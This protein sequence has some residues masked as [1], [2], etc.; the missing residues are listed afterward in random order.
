MFMQRRGWLLA[1]TFLACPPAWAGAPEGWVI[2][3]LWSPEYCKIHL[4]SKE[5]QCQE[6]RYFEIGGLQPQFRSGEEPEC[7]SGSLPAD[8]VD[9]A[10]TTLSNKELLRRI[11]RTQGACSGLGRDEYLIALD[12][13]R[14]RLVV[15]DEYSQV[16]KTP[17]ARSR[18]ALMESFRKS[19]PGLEPGQALPDCKGKWLY[20]VKVCVDADF[21]FR[22]CT[23]EPARQCPEDLQLRQLRRG[24]ARDD[25]EE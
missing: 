21:R 1:L 20:E 25:P 10:M 23:I 13:A 11:W 16:R 17:L 5:P 18:G 14:R 12:R 4:G 24:V 22:A 9:R 7:E 15:P 6:E 2:S 8:V 3:L 19:N